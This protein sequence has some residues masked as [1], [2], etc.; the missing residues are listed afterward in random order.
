MWPEENHVRRL[1]GKVW[2][3]FEVWEQGEEGGA[4]LRLNPSCWQLIQSCNLK[5][6]GVV[7]VV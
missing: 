6:W 1:R 3:G 7:C 4:W 5:S 2:E